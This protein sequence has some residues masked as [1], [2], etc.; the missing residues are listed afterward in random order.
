[1][2]IFEDMRLHIESSV[3]ACDAKLYGCEMVPN[4]KNHILRIFI[5]ADTPVTDKMCQEV[6][7]HLMTASAVSFPAILNYT[8]EISSPGLDRRL[9]T[10]E[11]CE[12]SLGKKVKLRT[13]VG[14]EGQRNFSGTL[15][16]VVEQVLQIKTSNTTLNINWENI[17]KI[18]IIYE[19]GQ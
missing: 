11:Q 17:D 1:M 6:G 19:M 16:S 10:V 7:Q 3:E 2:K 14:I 4:N 12:A 8:L 5:D 18:R 9:F 13:K 15:I